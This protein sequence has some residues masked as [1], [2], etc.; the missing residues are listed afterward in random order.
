[1]N[2]QPPSSVSCPLSC[3]YMYNLGVKRILSN[4]FDVQCIDD[5][6]LHHE[7]DQKDVGR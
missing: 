7:R 6:T 5:A 1:M 2:L 3:M 4:P